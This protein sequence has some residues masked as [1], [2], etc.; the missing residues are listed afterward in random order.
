[1]RR[2]AEALVA[3]R[4]DGVGQWI[5]NIHLVSTRPA[6]DGFT[7]ERDRRSPSTPGA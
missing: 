6:D 7:F 1:M 2:I 3:D 5:R 4:E